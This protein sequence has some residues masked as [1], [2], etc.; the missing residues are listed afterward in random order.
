MEGDVG[1]N[2]RNAKGGSCNPTEGAKHPRG[3]EEVRRHASGNVGTE[4]SLCDGGFTGVCTRRV[5]VAECIR[6]QGV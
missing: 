5:V 3:E 1:P 2:L 6:G 4:A